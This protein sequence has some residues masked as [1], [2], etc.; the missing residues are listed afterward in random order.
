MIFNSE[1]LLI[2]EIKNA[3]PNKEFHSKLSIVDR[4]KAY[5]KADAMSVVTH[6]SF[7]GSLDLLRQVRKLTNKPILAKDFI[8]TPEEATALKEAGGDGILLTNV[9]A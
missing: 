2:A 8:R 3:R 9:S 1:K 5:E 7:S 6:P 4:L